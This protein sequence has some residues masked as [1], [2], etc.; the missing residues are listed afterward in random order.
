MSKTSRKTARSHWIGW[1]A[2]LCVLAATLAGCET[3]PGPYVAKSLVAPDV[4]YCN[5]SVGHKPGNQP[6]ALGGKCCCTPSEE[7]MEQLHRDGFCKDMTAEQLRS[8]YEQKGIALKGPGHTRCNGLC[9]KGLHVV[10]G[11]RCMCPPTPGTEYYER[12]IAGPAR[13]APVAAK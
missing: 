12:V 1:A 11:G 2:A 3:P 4:V 6:W 7:L 10:L 9:A 5:D 13:S 8:L